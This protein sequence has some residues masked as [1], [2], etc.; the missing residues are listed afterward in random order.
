MTMRMRFINT[1]MLIVAMAFLASC[2][3][4]EASTNNA[5]KELTAKNR[6]IAAETPKHKVVYLNTQMFIDQIFDYK[7]NTKQWVYK[8]D[9]PAIID[10][11]TDWCGPCK[12][13][14]P[15]MEELAA[16]YDGQIRIYKMNTE[17]EPEVAGVFGIRSIP[18][19]LFIPVNGQPTM[20]TGAYPKQHYIDL[21]NENLLKK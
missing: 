21:I 15:I 4:T 3:N 9:K 12:R 18:S 2:N 17:K 7:T 6:N 13:V 16:E 20:Y 10:F 5:S 11:Y 14:A 19:I 8:S 1:F